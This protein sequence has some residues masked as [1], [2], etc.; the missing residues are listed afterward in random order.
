[1]MAALSPTER[2]VLRQ[3]A[4]GP[5]WLRT[6]QPVKPVVTRLIQRGWLRRCGPLR[7]MVM[8]TARGGLQIG[9]EVPPASPMDRFAENLSH[10]GDVARAATE[11]GCSVP[12]GRVLL[13]RIIARLGKEQCR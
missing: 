11:S 13:Q 1:M 6:F 2:K 12:Y 5:Q 4:D 10:H 8:L 9:I 7:N 3:L